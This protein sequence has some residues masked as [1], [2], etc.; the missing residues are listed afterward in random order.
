MSRNYLTIVYVTISIFWI[1]QVS[2][3]RYSPKPISDNTV[4][5]ELDATDI[6]QLRLKASTVSNPLLEPIEIDYFN[7]ISPDEAAVMTVV[8]NQELRA[9]RDKNGLARAQLLQAG[10]LPNPQLSY[11]LDFPVGGTTLG[12]VNAFGLIFGWDFTSLITREADIGAARAQFESVDLDIA[13]QEWQ[14]A[15]AAKQQVYHLYFLMKQHEVSSQEEIELLKNVDSIKKAVDYGDMTIIDLSAAESTLKAVQLSS[16]EIEQQ[17][18]EERIKLNKSLGIP[19]DENIRLDANIELPFSKKIPSY[20]EIISEIEQRR[21][22]LVALRLGYDSQEATLRAAVLGQFPKV[23]IGF[24]QLRDTGNVVTSGFGISIDLPIF[25][26]NQGKIAI[27][28]ATRQQLFDEYIDRVYKARSTIATILADISSV[29]K[30]ID[31]TEEAVKSL[32]ILVHTYYEA[33]LEGNADVISYYTAKKDLITKQIDVF[34]LKQSLADHWIALELES[35]K[36][37]QN[38][39]LKREIHQ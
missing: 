21:L 18:N 16:I 12:T 28:S 15:E 33:F 4:S 3:T 6:E 22:D 13:W 7:G 20:E 29:K 5:Q 27:E 34:K 2:C 11:T 36:Y 17:I 1:L 9:V 10:L 19:P 30:Q 31:T 25:D 14:L 32:N 39:N 38:S 23:N 8:G 24:S 26:H 37:M 35:G